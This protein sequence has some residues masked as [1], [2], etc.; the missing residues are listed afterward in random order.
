[1]NDSRIRPISAL[2]IIGG[3]YA[4]LGGI[5]VA[6]G[7]G[8]GIAL[9]HTEVMILG[10]I[11]T[12]IGAFFLILGLIFLGIIAARRANQ[13]R[14]VEQGRYI[15]GEVTD[16]SVNYNVRINHAHPYYLTVR[17]RDTAG[18]T[19]IFRSDSLR[20]YPDPSLIGKQVKVYISDD[21]FRKYYVD[22]AGILP[23]FIVH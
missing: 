6:L 14:L 5:F 18:R 20:L 9:R 23:E 16:C 2:G 21:S 3:V 22:A 17:C 7:I 11:F 15:W 12:T 13:R 4:L 1:M 10:M 19:H 8:L